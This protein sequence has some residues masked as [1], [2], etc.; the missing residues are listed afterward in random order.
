[1]KTH[2]SKFFLLSLG[3]HALGFAMMWQNTAHGGTTPDAS[4]SQVSHAP[5]VFAGIIPEKSVQ[6][7]NLASERAL[8]NESFL[9][10]SDIPGAEI[11]PVPSAQ[12][13]DVKKY[14]VP[15][16]EPHQEYVTTGKLTRLPAPIAE[17]D[18][19]VDEVKEVAVAGS[20]RLRILINADGTVAEVLSADDDEALRVFSER[21]AGIFKRTRFTPGEIN[22]RA[23]KAQLEINVVSEDM[24]AL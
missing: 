4:S 16:S 13:I 9:S 22:G 17:I 23:V 6:A 20:V 15:I 14:E 11:G 12:K 18:L 21:V 7:D 3:L 2:V 19:D 1:M 24:Q 5:M 8:S 10:D